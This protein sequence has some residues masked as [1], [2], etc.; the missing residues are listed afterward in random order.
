MVVVRIKEGVIRAAKILTQV[1]VTQSRQ[2]CAGEQLEQRKAAPRTHVGKAAV[3]LSGGALRGLSLK[4]R[5][6]G[7]AI[8]REA[9]RTAP[10]S[11]L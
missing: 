5:R 8:I 6:N 2:D 4:L 11:V 9:G 3:G 7:G 1:S 10:F